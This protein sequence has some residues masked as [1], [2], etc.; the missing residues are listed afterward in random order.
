[1]LN[2]LISFLKENSFVF[3]LIKLTIIWV[4]VKVLIKYSYK[5]IDKGINKKKSGLEESSY[6]RIET[7]G[8]VAKSTL[9]YIIYFLGAIA[10]LTVIFGPIPLTFA[11]I[12]AAIVGLGTQNLVKDIVSGFFILFEGQYAIGD[13]VTVLNYEG[14]VES[15]ELRVTKI[16]AFNGD[17]YIIPN[18]SIS[19]V[20]NHSNG[21]QRFEV[22]VTVDF[23]E[24]TSKV[25]EILNCCC[26]LLIKDN[27]NLVEETTVIGISDFSDIGVTYRILGMAKPLNKI[28]LEANLRKIIKEEFNSRG[29]EFAYTKIKSVK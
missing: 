14:I 9:K 15:V 4:I 17:L 6:K 3:I 28:M 1:M 20:V 29:V 19:S 24:T 22:F 26:D 12:G 18:G 21:P 13:N 25:E 5:I 16:R 27:P 11:G 8:N 7:L 2:N 10:G 23:D